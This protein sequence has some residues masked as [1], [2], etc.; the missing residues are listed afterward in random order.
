MGWEYLHKEWCSEWVMNVDKCSVMHN[1][2]KWCK[3]KTSIFSVGGE[4]VKVVGSCKYLGCI[5]NEHMDCREMVRERATAGRGALSAWLWRCRM[6]VGEVRGKTFVKFMEALVESALM[7]GAEV[8]ENCK[9]LDCI[10]HVQLRDYTI[11]LRVG[12]LHPKTSLQMEMGLLPLKREAKK[13][14]IE[15]L[16]QVYDDGRRKAGDKGSNERTVTER[17]S[18]VAREFGATSCGLWMG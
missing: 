7:Y 8:W 14:C 1:K 13:R 12:R 18:E 15:F 4:R 2:K 3:E 11:F 17:E 5:V 6:S 9:W 10:E 16:A